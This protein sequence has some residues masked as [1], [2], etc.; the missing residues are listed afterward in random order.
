MRMNTVNYDVYGVVV[1][2]LVTTC[3]VNLACSVLEGQVCSMNRIRLDSLESN[4]VKELPMLDIPWPT[5]T[6]SDD[7]KD[8]DAITYEWFHSGV[9]TVTWHGQEIAGL[10]HV[11]A[12]YAEQDTWLVTW[13]GDTGGSSGTDYERTFPNERQ[14]KEFIATH[15]AAIAGGFDVP[16]IH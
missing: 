16:D 11:V 7:D 1:K 2:L 15:A 13:W 14:A 9:A 4:I 6:P 10:E 12:A 5:P 8:K 3:G